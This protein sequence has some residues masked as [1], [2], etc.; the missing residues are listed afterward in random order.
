MARIEAKLR[1][2]VPAE[3][4]YQLWSNPEEY[5]NFMAAVSSGRKK[6]NAYQLTTEVK[7]ARRNGA[8]RSRLTSLEKCAGAT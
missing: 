2:G 7:T 4:A 6:A 1:V 3:F 8:W 5:L